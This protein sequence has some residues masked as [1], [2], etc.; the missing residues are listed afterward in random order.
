M[1][2]DFLKGQ[3]GAN[4]PH[5]PTPDQAN[6]IDALA[7]FVLS[8]DDTQALLITGFAG[9]GKTSLLSAFVK[10]MEELERP[11]V[12]LAP[13]G[14]AAKVFALYSGHQAYTIHKRI[15]RQKSVEEPDFSLNFNSF[16]QHIFIVDEAS[17]ISDTPDTTFLHESLLS[18]LIHFI[19]GNGQTH[20]RLILMGDTAQ[21]PPVGQEESPALQP[22]VLRSYGLNVMH[23]HLTQIVRQQTQSG[24]LV[25]ATRLR[26]LIDSDQVYELP[27]IQFKPFA[28]VINVPGNELID[29]LANCYQ[30]FGRDETIVV[31]RSN[32]RAIVYNQGIRNQILW[33][34]EELTTGDQIM[35]AKNNYF[36]L[37]KL[38]EENARMQQQSQPQQ[39]TPADR[40]QFL[41]NGDIA[42]VQRI[43]NERALYGFRFADCT[44][45]LPDYDDLEFDATILLDT[46]HA[47]APALTPQQQQSLYERVLADYAD[48]PRKADRLKAL[49]EDI[50]FNALQVKYAYA[51]TCHKAQGG[52]WSQVFVD[53]GYITEEMMGADYFRWLYT[54]LTRATHTAYFVNWR[55]EQT[56]PEDAAQPESSPQ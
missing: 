11:C 26:Q 42:I 18:D 25:N 4:F 19:Y 14:R 23:A 34:E 37:R 52:Q 27:R 17:M 22:S 8:P 35:I 39:E 1:I 46:L 5:Q 16:R 21:L 12:L 55:D 54:A 6:A 36:W 48:I 13:T 53:Q 33:M 44:L 45:T 43:R 9:T 15:Y 40:A 30:R 2:E 47:E 51:V 31:T 10:T 28:D 38:Q 50:Y 49:K 24:I 56:L 29:A 32:R 7:R 20:C 41:A 3:I